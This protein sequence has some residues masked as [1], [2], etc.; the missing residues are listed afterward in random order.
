[1][2]PSWLRRKRLWR[3]PKLLLFIWN[4]FILQWTL[5]CTAVSIYLKEPW[6]RQYSVIFFQKPAT[7]MRFVFAM[8]WKQKAS[9]SKTLEW[10]WILLGSQH[11]YDFG[12]EKYLW[13]WTEGRNFFLWTN[14]FLIKHHSDFDDKSNQ[15]CG[16]TRST[17]GVCIVDWLRMNLFF[18]NARQL[19]DAV[20]VTAKRP[21]LKV[22]FS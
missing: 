16:T 10:Y 14:H 7:S 2:T 4:V 3:S 22:T 9:S 6:H 12:V 17:R 21:S 18:D 1:M 15:T 20:L 13:W 19:G 5:D 8:S 11:Y